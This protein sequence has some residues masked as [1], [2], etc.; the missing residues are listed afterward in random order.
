M[1]YLAKKKFIRDCTKQARKI[2]K[3][4]KVYVVRECVAPWGRHGV[5][6]KYEVYTMTSCGYA[7]QFKGQHRE[8]NMAYIL[9]RA[10]EWSVGTPPARSTPMYEG[11]E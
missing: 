10:E 2:P 3:G 9:M 1:D 6:R 8:Q 11:D 4:A 7:K 5:E